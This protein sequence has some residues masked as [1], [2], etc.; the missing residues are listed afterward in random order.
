MAHNLN[1]N[2][3]TGKYSFFSVKEMPWHGLGTIVEQHPTSA[4]AIGHAGLDY[5]V[6]RALLSTTGCIQDRTEGVI[7][8]EFESTPVEGHFATQRMDT[9]QVLGV[10]GKDYEVIQNREAFAFFDAIVGGR[11]GILYETAGALGNGERI[12]ITATLPD[13]IRVGSDDLIKKY[14]FLT[15]A[16][17]GTG[18]IIAAFTPVR[19]VCANTLSVALSGMSNVVRIKHTANAKARLEQAHRI[20]GVANTLSGQM[21]DVFNQWAK[22]KVPDHDLQM[23]IRMTFSSHDDVLASIQEGRYEELSAVYRNQCEDTFA[24]ALMSDTQQAET[25]AG[26][27]FGVFNAVTGYFQN[28]RTYKDDEKKVRS[29]MLGGTAAK[30]AQKAFDLCTGY[31]RYGAD[32]FNSLN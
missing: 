6:S 11:D 2:P 20:M 4:E 27:L 7:P 8:S 14:I 21:E 13:Y 24:Y 32:I 3:L 10:V 26:T 9:G 12:F 18:S 1:F 17:D 30:R 15:T 25:T 23:L 28:V 22:I 19:I 5:E 29:I 31:A 16:H